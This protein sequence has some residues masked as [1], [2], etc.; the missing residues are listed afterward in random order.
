MHFQSKLR[1]L[2]S[3]VLLLVASSCASTSWWGIAMSGEETVGVTS[4]G[5]TTEVP[6]GDFKLLGFLIFVI[7]SPL[8]VAF[9]TVALPFQIVRG[10][11]PYGPYE[12]EE[13]DQ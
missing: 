10:D 6:T 13:D 1:I 9:D 11:P 12:S 4:T 7:G 5:G 8:T 2:A 3:C